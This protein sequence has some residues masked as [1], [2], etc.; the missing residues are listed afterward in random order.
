MRNDNKG[1]PFNCSNISSFDE[2]KLHRYCSKEISNDQYPVNQTNTFEADPFDTKTTKESRKQSGFC[3]ES[4]M[5]M[6]KMSSP[7]KL[8]TLYFIYERPS[9]LD[10]ISGF[11]GGAG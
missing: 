11:V 4:L 3:F 5:K 10:A 2:S 9:Q 7:I 1:S 6:L 8:N